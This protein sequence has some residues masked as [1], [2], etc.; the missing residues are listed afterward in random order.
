MRIESDVKLDFKDVLLRPKRSTLGS[1]ANVDLD[2]RYRFRHAGL[3]MPVVPVIAAN[4]DTV[5]TIRDGPGI[6]QAQDP[7][8]HPQALSGGRTGVVLPAGRGRGQ[9]VRLLFAR[10]PRPRPAQVRAGLGPVPAAA[11]AGSA[12]TSRTATPKHSW[13]SSGGSASSIR[14]SSLMAGNVVTADMTEALI[15]AGVDIVKVGIGPGSVC[16]TR[17]MT[18]VGYP[19]LS[20]DHRMRRCRPR[21]RRAHLRRRRLHGAGRRGRRLS[22]AAPTS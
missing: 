5:G 4:M 10:H 15:L 11:S 1:R 2:R 3:D 14:T 13:I 8:G 21:P 19:Q 9:P 12:S 18:G 16:T 22:A 7:D 6:V 20:A 17:K